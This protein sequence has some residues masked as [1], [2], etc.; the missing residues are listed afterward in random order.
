MYGD[1]WKY[2]GT[3]LNG[4]IVRTKDG[5]PV[6]VIRCSQDGAAIQ[7][8]LS[9]RAYMV[10]LGDL[11]V[12]PVPLGYALTDDGLRYVVR[13]P[14]RR[15]WRQGLRSN[16]YAFI[17]EVGRVTKNE[18]VSRKDLANCILG[19]YQTASECVKATE[20]LPHA[21]FNRRWAIAK[22][23]LLYKN[24]VVGLVH[25]KPFVEFELMEDFSWLKEEL[26][27]V[28]DV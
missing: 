8:L 25:L 6:E 10:Q 12:S 28:S 19:N 15:D 17:D 24:M 21:V 14:M 11:D 22:G 7:E 2:A 20:I 16:N 18:K 23:S 3:R 13:K 9:D 4:T 27:E 1:D 5:V 26:M